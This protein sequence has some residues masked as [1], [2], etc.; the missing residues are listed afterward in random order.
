M[1]SGTRREIVR[2]LTKEKASATVLADELD[3]S[4]QTVHHHLRSLEA[5]GY[6]Q[7]AGTEEG[8]TRPHQLFSATATASLF[9]VY[10]G[11]V[12]ERDIELTDAH[13]LLFSVFEVPQSQF[14]FPL[15]S[16]LLSVSDTASGIVAIGVYGSVARGDATEESDIDVLFIT[17]TEDYS[18]PPGSMLVP[19]SY[20][21]TDTADSSEK[22]SRVVSLESFTREQL[23]EG[24]E[25]DSSFLRNAVIESIV[26]YDPHDVL[27]AAKS[28]YVEE[29]RASTGVSGRGE[30]HT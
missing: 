22:R 17:E 10:G 25:L 28:E 18:L 23:R 27:E 16:Y 14:H 8:K 12:V 19:E 26:L 21:V 6:V 9:S 3:L 5:D 24:K 13:E 30:S 15:L 4:L 7:E 20:D 1:L 2:I 29:G 11:K